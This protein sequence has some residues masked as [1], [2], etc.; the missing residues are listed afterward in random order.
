MKVKQTARSGR[1][2]SSRQLC[3]PP[4]TDIGVSQLHPLR[5]ERQTDIYEC[6]R[7]H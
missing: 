4:Y 7:T 5:Q 1:S 2:S 3:T 6:V